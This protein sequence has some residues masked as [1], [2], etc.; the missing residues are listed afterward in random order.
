MIQ[1]VH[2]DGRRETSAR[3]GIGENGSHVSCG[4]CVC[5][6]VCVCLSVCARVEVC[7]RACA[8]A[9]ARADVCIFDEH[10]KG[11]IREL[12]KGRTCRVYVAV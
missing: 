6:C 10:V 4:V 8:R 1:S 9:S 3:Q 7:V 2:S 5:V 12:G 11:M